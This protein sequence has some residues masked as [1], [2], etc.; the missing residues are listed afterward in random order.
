MT[1][2]FHTP[3]PDLQTVI[4]TLTRL[5]AEVHQL[6]NRSTLEPYELE[7]LGELNH[8]IHKILQFVADFL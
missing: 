8:K 3:L 1:H 4:D 2:S 7:R 5:Q 6:S